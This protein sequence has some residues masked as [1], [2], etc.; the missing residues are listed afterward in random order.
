MNAYIYSAS[1]Y[2]EPCGRIIQADTVPSEDSETYP[3]GP[4]S[5]GGG[6]ADTPQHCDRCLT[7]LENP[8]TPDGIEYV[9][10]KIAQSNP[11]RPGVTIREWMEFYG[12]LVSEPINE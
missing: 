3:Q 7:F 10:E 12:D 4:Y 2:C 6:E 11:M 9:R 8:L 5:D 1:I